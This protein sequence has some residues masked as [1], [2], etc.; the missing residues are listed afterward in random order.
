MTATWNQYLHQNSVVF[1]EPVYPP[2][3]CYRCPLYSWASFQECSNSLRSP[4]YT[5]NSKHLLV[6][7]L[8]HDGLFFIKVNFDTNDT[9]LHL[10]PLSI[11]KR[12]FLSSIKT[13]NHSSINVGRPLILLLT[14]TCI[15]EIYL[16][17]RLITIIQINMYVLFL[18][19]KWYPFKAMR[20]ILSRPCIHFLAGSLKWGSLAGM[21]ILK[22]S[23]LQWK[24]Y[25]KKI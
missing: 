7:H 14:D 6:I 25:I 23:K 24:Y 17:G 9:T 4:S 18:V 5:L 21:A 1:L 16:L 10:T 22:H 15:S 13:I 20:Q 11:S 3:L 19:W 8:D 2:F 12:I